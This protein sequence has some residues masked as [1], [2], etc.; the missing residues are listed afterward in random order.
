MVHESFASK[1]SKYIQSALENDWKEG[2]EKHVSLTDHEPET[3][4]GY[5][6]WLYTKEI[7][8]KDA[9]N[10]CH[11]HGPT[12]SLRDQN[13]DCGYLYSLKLVKMYILGDYMSDMRFC[14]AIIDGMALMRNCPPSPDAIQWVWTHT[15]EDCPLRGHLLERWAGLL[16]H[17]RAAVYMKENMSKL[18]KDFMIDLLI[19]TGTDQRA[20][21]LKT[22]KERMTS[23]E[24][25]KFHRH[26]DDSD[27]CG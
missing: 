13:A 2:Q 3:L 11:I 26:V 17:T 27:R 18:P 15:M 9:E 10:K 8:L 14:N 6:N 21:I 16:G 19:L 23:V 25:C 5:I 24:E 7:T 20:E 22:F 12:Y 4:E 1:S